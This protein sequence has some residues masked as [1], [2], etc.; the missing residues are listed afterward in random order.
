MSV[1]YART[2]NDFGTLLGSLEQYARAEHYFQQA[3]ALHLRLQGPNHRDLLHV[4]NNLGS[5][6]QNLGDFERAESYYRRAL[7]LAERLDDPLTGILYNNLAT[8][9]DQ[10]GDYAAGE[11]FLLKSLERQKK[12]LGE[13]HHHV[14]LSWINLASNAFYQ[15]NY[16]RGWDYVSRAKTVFQF[17]LAPDHPD[18][19]YLTMWQGR[20]LNRL[21]RYVEADSL[22]QW[23]IGVGETVLPVNHWYVTYCKLELG[24]ALVLQHR[25]KEAERL[26]RQTYQA[27]VNTPGD[28]AS[29][30][31]KCQQYLLDAWQALGNHAAADSLRQILEKRSG[32]ETLPATQ[33]R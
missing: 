2:L 14:G 29:A 12:L 15:K 32:R 13:N 33:E 20:I 3:L 17:A 9:M 4:L 16:S 25:H 24:A 11:K 21:G 26:L 8:L 19:V 18:H 27:L 30:I 31:R 23:A 28:N 5:N 10:K 22:L 6:Y 7:S 1:A